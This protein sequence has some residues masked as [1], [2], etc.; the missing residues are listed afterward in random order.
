MASQISTSMDLP[1][2][3]GTYILALTLR[4]PRRMDIGKLGAYAFPAGCYLYVGS[5]LGGLRGRVNRHL[6]ANK[7][8]HWHIDYLTLKAPIVNVWWATGTMRRECAW[9]RRLTLLPEASVPAPG[10]GASDC[11]CETHLFRLPE[12]P[13]LGAVVAVNDDLGHELR[14]GHERQLHSADLHRP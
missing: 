1:R 10:F 9:V 5:A 2:A 12:Q 4:Q 13:E 11:R 14:V 8:I 7:R 3:G 6:R